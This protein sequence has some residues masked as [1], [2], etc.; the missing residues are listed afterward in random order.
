MAIKSR[1]RITIIGAGN[2]GST[3]AMRL[4]HRNLGDIILVDVVTGLARGKALD[5]LEM[6]P[7]EGFDGHLLGTSD[8]GETAG[9]DVTVICAGASRKPGMS[10]E[11]LLAVNAA[12]VRGA[13]EQTLRWSPESFLIIVTNPVD[14]MTYLAKNVSGLPRQRV[15]GM[16]GV[17]DSARLR[18]FIAMELDFSPADV[19]T[20]VLGGHGDEMVPIV[21]LTTAGGVPVRDLLPE[22]TIHRAVE[23]ARAGGGEIVNLLQS[24]SA[25]YAP[26]AAVARMVDSLLG[27]KRRV[28]NV[29]GYLEGEYGHYDVCAGVPGLVGPRGLEKVVEVELDSDEKAL[30]D[31][32][33]RRQ[34]E[35]VG[36]MQELGLLNG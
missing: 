9:S 20:M 17:L 6:A 19:H 34:R 23:R 16:A 4:A 2:V 26:G 1:P 31:G 22:E 35:L 8:Y 30:F 24:G 14:A 13:V 18:A 27:N 15:M 10:R 7:V 12:I 25:F 11:D 29:S 32:S 36:K 5:I 28:L 33:V 3:A 21:R